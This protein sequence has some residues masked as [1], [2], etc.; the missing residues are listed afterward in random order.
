MDLQKIILGEAVITYAIV[1][2]NIKLRS[3]FCHSRI[4]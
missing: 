2:G 1:D 3:Q 4:K